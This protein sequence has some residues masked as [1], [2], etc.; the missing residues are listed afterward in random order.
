M[1]LLRYFF[2]E[3]PVDLPTPA[4]TLT[5]ESLMAAA[6]LAMQSAGPVEDDVGAVLDALAVVFANRP[7]IR[8][9]ILFARGA[10][11]FIAPTF[12][13]ALAA[14]GYKIVRA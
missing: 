8:A 12:R 6:P 2:E 10:V 3:N 14:A 9:G 11:D 7:I 1:N 5:P 4:V 13:S